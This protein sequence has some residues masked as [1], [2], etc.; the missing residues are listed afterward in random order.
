MN[1]VKSLL[2]HLTYLKEH[3]LFKITIFIL[4]AI[5]MYFVMLSNVK[6]EKL[7]LSLYSVAKKDVLSPI[8]VEDKEETLKRQQAAMASVEDQ[9]VLKNSY[10]IDRVN[11]ISELFNSVMDVKEET[12]ESE[13]PRDEKVDLLF[14]DVPKELQENLPRN[15]F[16]TLLNASQANLDTAKSTTITAVQQA[17]KETIRVGLE[18]EKKNEVVNEINQVNIDVEI[19]DAMATIAQYAIVANYFYDIQATE[20]KKQEALDSISPVNIRSGQVLVK[21]GQKIDREIFRQ[22]KLVGLLDDETDSFIYIGLFLFVCLLTGLIAYFF[23][24]VQSQ[25][26]S[27]NTNL[28]IYSIIFTFTILI[29]KVISLFPSSIDFGVIVPIAMTSMLLKMLINERVA[30]LTGVVFAVIGGI[31]F[32]IDLLSKFNY[33]IGTYLLFSSLAGVI[34]LNSPNRRSKILKAGFLISIINMI[35]ISALFMMQSGHFSGIEIGSYLLLAFSSGFISAVLT[36]GLVPVFEAGFGILSTMKLIELSNPNHPLLRKILIEA[37]GTY[38][39]SIMVANLSDAAS[40]A[41]G[42]NGL[43]AR[44]GSYY[45][46]IGKTK[47]P[48][49]FIE[50]QMN[51]ENPHDKV[52][53]YISKK[54]IIAHPYDGSKLLKEYKIPQ[55]IIDI[56]EQHHGT[57]LVKYFYFK[58]KEAS[59]TEVLESEFRYP[60]PK[61]QSKEA[62]IVAIADSVE[63]AVRSLKRPTPQKIEDMVRAIISDKLQDGQFNECDITLKELDL[64]AKTMCE[65]LKGIFH[66]RIEYP[67]NQTNKKVKEA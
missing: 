59:D 57:S 50:N 65:M 36:L 55:E 64:A 5:V 13:L 43:L 1:L 17:M 47:R 48:H 37:P 53:P 16:I 67:E 49:F 25:S 38:H 54:V 45:H 29:M 39:H 24:D 62:A 51:I 9:Y 2:G 6:P 34:F 66:Q 12:S 56:T 32:N 30:I 14:K 22:L 21:E 40:E 28:M 4:L 27:E 42:A 10:G 20:E 31:I 63:A 33:L 41:V 61:P 7:D 46:D 3:Q 23:K 18:Q 58:A 44:V 52:S 8:T 35:T 15:V 19:R 60:G 11:L 26:R